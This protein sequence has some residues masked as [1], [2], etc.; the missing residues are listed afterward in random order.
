MITN[1][2]QVCFSLENKQLVPKIHVPIFLKRKKEKKYIYIT[3]GSKHIIEEEKKRGRKKEEK[4][5][6]PK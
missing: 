6:N 5:T 4:E 3:A 1:A 2:S